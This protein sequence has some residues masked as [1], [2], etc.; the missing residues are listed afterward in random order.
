MEP[1]KSAE[2]QCKLVAISN[3]D[4]L[5]AIDVRITWTSSVNLPTSPT[6]VSV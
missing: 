6:E 3:N 4:K 1:H 5:A 2:L